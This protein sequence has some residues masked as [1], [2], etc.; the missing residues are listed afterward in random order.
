MGSRSLSV[1]AW[2]FAGLALLVLFFGWPLMIWRAVSSGL[3][4]GPAVLDSMLWPVVAILLWAVAR[5]LG[6]APTNDLRPPQLSGAAR[7]RS[8]ALIPSDARSCQSPAGTDQ[9]IADGTSWL[10][11]ASDCAHPS[12]ISLNGH[13]PTPTPGAAVVRVVMIASIMALTITRSA[14]VNAD[15]VRA[16]VHSLSQDWCR[17]RGGHCTNDSERNQRCFNPH[18]LLLSV[19]LD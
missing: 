14:D 3:P 9:V 8:Q 13:R 19:F 18:K 1:S 4:I 16:N 5:G 12:V 2:V 11:A 6:L 7:G 10:I 15:P 17:C